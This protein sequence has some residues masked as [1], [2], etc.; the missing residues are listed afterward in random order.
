M[1]ADT[2]P[3]QAEPV[4]AENLAFELAGNMAALLLHGKAVEQALSAG[5]LAALLGCIN[6]GIELEKEARAALL[7]FHEWVEA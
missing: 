3:D 7:R 5:N 4:T 6:E 1:S 2:K